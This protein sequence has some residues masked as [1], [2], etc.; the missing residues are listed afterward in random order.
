MEFQMEFQAPAAELG[1]WDHI[2][3]SMAGTQRVIFHV[4]LMYF[5]LQAP[6]FFVSVLLLGFSY[7]ADD[8]VLGYSAI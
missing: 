4:Y 3:I 8:F 5:K 6:R 7:Q 1:E 2:Y